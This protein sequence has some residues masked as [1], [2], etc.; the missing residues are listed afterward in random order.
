MSLAQS[1]STFEKARSSMKFTTGSRG[2]LSLIRLRE[3]PQHPVGHRPETG[4]VLL[5]T[6]GKPHVLVHPTRSLYVRPAKI[7]ECDDLRSFSAEMPR[8]PLAPEADSRPDP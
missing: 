3:R 6:F 7:V 5:E 1:G 8:A 4:P 2:A